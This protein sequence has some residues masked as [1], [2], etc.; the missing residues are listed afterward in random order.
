MTSVKNDTHCGLDSSHSIICSC[1]VVFFSSC[2]SAHSKHYI[3]TCIIRLH[4]SVGPIDM[5]RSH[6]KCGTNMFLISLKLPH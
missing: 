6:M 5:I 3:Y 4:I 2:S 1:N